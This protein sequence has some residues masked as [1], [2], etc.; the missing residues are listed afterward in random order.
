MSIFSDFEGI[1]NAM[2]HK[3]Y[4]AIEEYLNEVCPES[5]IAEYEKALSE[6]NNLEADEWLKKKDELENKYNI[7]R[8]DDVLYKQ[9]EFE[10][11][12]DWYQTKEKEGK[13]ESQKKRKNKG[14]EAR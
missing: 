7:V 5:V 8:L 6:I 14:R 11:F 4:D 9:K 10:K 3:K 13:E 12:D 1:R 2:G